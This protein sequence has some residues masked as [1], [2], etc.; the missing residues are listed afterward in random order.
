MAREHLFLLHGLGQTPQ[1]WQD[2][3]VAM[4][5]DL[6]MS[7]PWLHG[8]RPGREAPFSLV[9][10]ANN[11]GAVITSQ[12]VQRAFLCGINVGAMVAMQYALNFDASASDAPASDNPDADDPATD[13]GVVGGLILVAPQIAPPKLA[14]RMQ[15]LAIKAMPERRLA[16]QGIQKSAMMQV[17]DAMAATNFS[18]R[19]AQIT[20]PT[21]VLCGNSDRQAA[22][23]SRQLAETLP[24]ARLQIIEGGNHPNLDSPQEFN[25]AVTGFLEGHRAPKTRDES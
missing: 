6:P 17:L 7:A 13:A 12:G 18:D 19:L 24:N 5:A 15:R 20:A 2:Q 21:L 4:P 1:M 9:D 23:A 11:L 16:S 10:S 22:A 25:N 3:V 8:L 14:M